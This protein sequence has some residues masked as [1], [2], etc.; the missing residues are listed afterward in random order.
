MT[1]FP[2]NLKK[3]G[4]FMFH[5]LLLQR[6]AAGKPIRVGV[7]GAGKFGASLVLQLFYMKGIRAAAIA[8]LNLDRARQAYTSCGIPAEMICRVQKVE[9]L[10][11][12]I[13][14]GKQVITEDGLL[15][16]RCDF[17]DVVVEAT[18]NP[19]AGA[20]LAYHVL[21]NKKHLVMVNVEADVT[22]GPVLK[23]MADNAGVV[24]S[25]VDGD[26]PGVIMN[27]VNWA[28]TVGFEIVAAG[29]GTVFYPEDRAGTPDTVPARMGFSEEKIQRRGLNLKMYNSFR[30]GS[31]AQIEMAALANMTGLLPDV[32][33]MHEPSL[34]LSDIPRVFSLK[35]EGGI[36]NQEGVVELANRVAEDGKALLPFPLRMGVFVVI[37]THHPFL[38]EDLTHFRL[39]SGGNGQNFL[40]YRP[41]HLVSVEAPITILKAALYQQ[42][43][44]APMGKPVVDVIALAKRNLKEGERLDGGG[45]YAVNGL[46]EK[47][48]VAK[49]EQLMP[50]ELTDGV[51]LKQDVAE[52]TPISYG[53]VELN[54]HSFLLQL[55]RIQDATVF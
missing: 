52:G 22:V 51:R 36:L 54:E 37:K 48:E 30:D 15:L 3:E 50:L 34:N 11:E 4:S 2:A 14:R 42:A 12:A 17:L 49:A 7:I 55:R 27:M 38:Q 45:S 8:D 29:R 23:R 46:I 41:Y 13:L 40:L 6:E 5:D 32:R 1:D 16:A 31:K 35:Q 43:T 44:G 39:Y 21:L 10:H 19:E 28:R 26:Q 53:M 20:H 18:G 47:A 24:Y 33:G 9:D 25:L